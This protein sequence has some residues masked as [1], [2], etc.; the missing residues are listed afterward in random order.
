MRPPAEDRPPQCTVLIVTHQSARHIGA[1]LR[2]LEAQR[3][4]GVDLEVLVVDNASTDT[5]AAEVSSFPG[6]RLVPTG[7]NLGFAAAINIGC[8]LIPVGRPVLVLNPDLVLESWAVAELLAGLE[9]PAVGVVVPQ[10][11]NGDGTV[12][13]SLRHE[14][15]LAR[16]AVDTLFGRRAA[17]LPEG[18]SGMVWDRRAYGR[19]RSVD[20]AT[21][22]ALLVSGTCRFRVGEW[23]ARYFLYS[24]ETDYLRRV[25]EAGYRVRYRP[26]A[27]VRHVGAGSGSSDALAALCAVNTVRYYG[28]HHRRPAVIAYAGIVAVQQLLRARRPAARL[29]LRALLSERVRA[30]LPGPVPAPRLPAPRPVTLG[31]VEPG[32]RSGAKVVGGPEVRDGVPGRFVPGRHGG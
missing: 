6:V 28:R 9:D 1:L 20:W 16:A 25:R 5:T 26:T 11:R 14:P 17:W 29:A 23:D 21:G 22:A 31:R 24:E 3:A 7:A 27:V 2:T 10:L 18:W 12:C 32:I 30:T 4:A 13:P 8:R 19:E 15:S